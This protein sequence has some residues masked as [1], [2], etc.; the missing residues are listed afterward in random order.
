MLLDFW[1]GPDSRCDP[2]STLAML[3]SF[4]ATEAATRRSRAARG[5]S[6][7][8]VRVRALGFKVS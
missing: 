2:K 4:Q 7:G 5:R 3:P 1:S 6:D 8:L